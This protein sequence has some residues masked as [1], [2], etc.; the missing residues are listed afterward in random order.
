MVQLLDLAA[1]DILAK[2]IM[3]FLAKTGVRRGELIAMDIQ[4]INLEKMEFRVGPFRKRSNRLGFMDSELAAALREY[5][6]WRE[7]RAAGDALWITP[8]GSRVTRNYVY[9]TVT[10]SLQ[11]SDVPACPG[12]SSRSSEEIGAKMQL[13]FMIISRSRSYGVA[14]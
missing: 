10:F 13:T 14:T 1:R 5:L 6:D 4:D 12:N 7:P 11:C 2:N 3:L 8:A 9:L